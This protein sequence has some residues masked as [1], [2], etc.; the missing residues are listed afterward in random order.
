MRSITS[1]WTALGAAL[2]AVIVPLAA[3][4][5]TLAHAATVV[6]PATVNKPPQRTV[7]PNNATAYPFD[8][9]DHTSTGA[10][11]N[12][13]NI[14]FFSNS[15]KMVSRITKQ[16]KASGHGDPMTLNGSG[17]SR[18]GVSRTDPWSSTSKG[19]KQKHCWGACSPNDDVHLRMYGPDG[20]MG[21]QVYQ[22]GLSFH[23]K[24][25][26]FDYYLV[27]TVH[28]DLN[29][30]SPTASFGHQ[31][32]ARQTLVNHMMAT[33]LW[34]RLGNMSTGVR[35]VTGTDRSDSKYYIE[36]D[37]LAWMINIDS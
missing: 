10:R 32:T 29:E 34:T 17:P 22:G 25:Y 23:G 4:A 2:C 28:Y 1:R 31:N 3:T 9:W 11:D 27:A 16:L 36:E 24:P 8:A 6:K 19:H 26:A 12:T 37:G 35:A 13:V 18:A 30:G 14:V 5:A 20:S 7:S 21:T 33:H 15:P